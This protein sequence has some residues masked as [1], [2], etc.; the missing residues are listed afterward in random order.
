MPW[1]AG[2]QAAWLHIGEH[3][4]PVKM[5][6]GSGGV[7][8]GERSFVPAAGMKFGAVFTCNTT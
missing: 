3:I 7:K 6:S 2:V 5:N 1:K 4:E 8:V